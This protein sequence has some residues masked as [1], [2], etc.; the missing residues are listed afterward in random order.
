MELHLDL[1]TEWQRDDEEIRQ[2]GDVF[3]TLIALASYRSKVNHMYFAFIP[4]LDIPM[5]PGK[6]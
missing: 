4:Q 6:S 3:K 1:R 2:I 5:Q